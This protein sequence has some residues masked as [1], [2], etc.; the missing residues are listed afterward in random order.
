MKPSRFN[1]SEIQF[2]SDWTMWGDIQDHIE[3]AFIACHVACS[4]DYEYA[5]L[6]IALL[7]LHVRFYLDWSEV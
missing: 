2:Y 6:D 4:M 1:N 7:G 3:I 5:E